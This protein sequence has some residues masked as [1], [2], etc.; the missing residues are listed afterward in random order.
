MHL[1]DTSRSGWIVKTKPGDRI[2]DSLHPLYIV[3]LFSLLHFLLC[4]SSNALPQEKHFI[5]M[6]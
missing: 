1:A 3:Y 5:M 4:L 2:M 6:P